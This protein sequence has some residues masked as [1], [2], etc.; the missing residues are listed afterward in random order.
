MS[1]CHYMDTYALPEAAYLKGTR[2]EPQL[3]MDTY[4]AVRGDEAL[5]GILLPTAVKAKPGEMSCLELSDGSSFPGLGCRA[6]LLQL[7]KA[8]KSTWCWLS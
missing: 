3:S 2:A 7:P 8:K 1:T 4:T 5:L 6:E